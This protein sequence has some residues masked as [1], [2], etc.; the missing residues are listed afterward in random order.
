MKCLRWLSESAWCAECRGV[1]NAGCARR[2]VGSKA[3]PFLAEVALLRE[4]GFDGM[5]RSA[6]RR[7]DGW[8]GS[9]GMVLALST[10]LLID[11]FC[12]VSPQTSLATGAVMLPGDEYRAE[13]D[14]LSA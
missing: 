12:D 6:A 5:L 3:V 7:A 13:P 4:E 14:G 10:Y 1:G 8:R 11:E 2:F 9:G